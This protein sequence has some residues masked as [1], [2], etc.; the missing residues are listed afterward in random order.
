[1]KCT[2]IPINETTGDPKNAHTHVAGKDKSFPL[3][4]TGLFSSYVLY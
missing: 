4:Q 1:M 3:T 2:R